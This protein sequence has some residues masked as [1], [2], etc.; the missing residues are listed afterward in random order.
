MGG[1]SQPQT[2]VRIP[3]SPPHQGT[4]HTRKW[5]AAYRE[6]LASGSQYN[7]RVRKASSREWEQSESRRRSWVVTRRKTA[8]GV[9]SVDVS[10]CLLFKHDATLLASATWQ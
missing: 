1:T 4:R 6:T 9:G 2:R 7:A 10:R 3:A 5:G 8:V